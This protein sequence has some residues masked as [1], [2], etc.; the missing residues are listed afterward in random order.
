VVPVVPV[1]PDPVPDPVPDPDPEP[2]SAG[3]FSHPSGPPLTNSL[4]YMT[5]SIVQESF[6]LSAS[7]MHII[8]SVTPVFTLQHAALTHGVLTSQ[9]TPLSE[10]SGF[11]QLALT[12]SVA[13]SPC[14]VALVNS[15]SYASF[16]ITWFFS[17]SATQTLLTPATS[18]TG[19]QKTVAPVQTSASE[20]QSVPVVASMTGASGFWQFTLTP[21]LAAA[22]V[23]V[24]LVYSSDAPHV[25][26]FL[27]ALVTQILIV[28]LLASFAGQH[29]VPVPMQSLLLNKS[30]NEPVVDGRAQTSVELL[31]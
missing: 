6:A 12:L 23:S 22:P 30:H 29:S 21:S 11:S 20:E 25:F 8:D 10:S 14:A 26:R 5:P 16:H 31:V 17:A 15:K 18:V 24:V 9:T 27:S 4:V 3:A 2:P 28:L 19:Q 7:G 13:A 1:E